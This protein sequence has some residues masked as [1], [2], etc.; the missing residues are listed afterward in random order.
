[1]YN[2]IEAILSQY[3]MEIHE[4]TK[5]RG[6]YICDTN[7]GQ[8][9]LMAFRGSKEKGEFLRLFLETL[10]RMG[11]LVEQIERNK[12]GESVTMDEV[13]GDHFVIKDYVAGAELNTGRVE[14]LKAAV[15][16]LAEYH[17]TA[18]KLQL[19]IPERVRENADSVVEIRR[20]H[21]R[22][23][24]KVRNYIRGRKK[25]NSFEQM[26]MSSYETM[27]APAE[28]SLLVLEKQQERNP[29]ILVCHGDYNQHNVI[30]ADGRWRMVHFE[31]FIYSWSVLDLANFLRKMMEKNNWDVGLGVELIHTYNQV[32]S[33]SEDGM[34][35]LYGILLFPEKF[36]KVT[37]HYMN[38]RKSW[39][40]ERDVEK[41][42]KVI[43]QEAQRLFFVENLFSIPK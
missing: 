10:Q 16:L 31:N 36:W 26:F 23:I 33:L 18:G 19:S 24:T 20:R 6:A 9:L 21:Y 32:H 4:V 43:E 1:M 14:E 38:S 7:K 39:I 15:K 30:F 34:Q 5:G 29:E 3:E 40:S 28:K 8:K 12:I 25:K 13:T 22:E 2:Q 11:F 37:N 27:I 17:N 35:Q 42:K 41:L